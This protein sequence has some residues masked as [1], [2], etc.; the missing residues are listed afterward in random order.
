MCER[1]CVVCEGVLCVCGGVLCSASL[2][3][4][5]RSVCVCVL[6]R[7]VCVLYDVLEVEFVRC[8]K[9][10]CSVLRCVV[11]RSRLVFVCVHVL[12]CVAVCCGVL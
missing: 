11:I 10:R 7:C 4:R 2:R 5:E 8:G 12:Q 9:E 1:E 3:E 6:Y